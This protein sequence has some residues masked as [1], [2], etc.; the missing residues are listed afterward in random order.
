MKVFSATLGARERLITYGVGY[1]VGIGVPLALGISFALGFG[2]PLVFLF[3]LPFVIAFGL[4]SFFR[5]TGFGVT[6]EAIS[7]IRPVGL[8]RIPLN[9]IRQVVCPAADPLGPTIG[10]ARVEGIHGSFGT[11]WNRNWGRYRA[12]VTDHGKTVELRLADNSRV[13]LSPD[14]PIGFLR[15]VCNAAAESGNLV[16]VDGA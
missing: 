12:Y 7:I 9:E 4:P 1:G 15:A 2:E 6:S 3:P 16:E 13:I 10:V 11:Y 5:P 8:K 14:D